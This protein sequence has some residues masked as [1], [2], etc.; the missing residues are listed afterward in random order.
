MTAL[1]LVKACHTFA[2]KTAP[3]LHITDEQHYQET[4][5]AL[6]KLLEE[7]KDSPEDPLN[8]IIEMLSRAVEDYE[9]INP[10]LSRFEK[11][12]LKEPHELALVRTLMD[13]HNLTMN[14]LPEIGSKSMVS[15]VL[16]GERQL[17]KKHIHALAK[18]FHIKPALFFNSPS[19]GSKA[20]P[21]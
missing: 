20:S 3:Y 10:I 19:L 16:S 18:R 2:Q 8:I 15:R 1:A 14:D 6:E 13:Q 7:A 12:V 21:L 5:V 4:L 17:S 9:N 11:I